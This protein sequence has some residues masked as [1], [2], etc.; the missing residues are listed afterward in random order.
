MD[1]SMKRTG[2]GVLL[3]AA[4][5]MAGCA[6]HKPPEQPGIVAPAPVAAPPTAAGEW[7]QAMAAA[8]LA[9]PFPGGGES[10]PLVVEMGI[11]NHTPAAADTAALAGLL[12]SRLADSG[13]MRFVETAQRDAA[14]Q[15]Q[16]VQ[17]SD[18]PIDLQVKLG[19]QLG[20]KYMLT[21][22]LVPLTREPEADGSLR[23]RLTLEI[24]DLRSILVILR[25]P[26]AYVWK[27]G[28]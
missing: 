10:Q 1:V 25:K 28:S 15:A 11:V 5:M 9:H 6:T 7:A 27:P 4:L 8:I 16:Q 23:C 24:T 17:L 2:G 13:R 3:C 18:C 14:M 20:A 22:S 12:T 26:S 21:G 19:R